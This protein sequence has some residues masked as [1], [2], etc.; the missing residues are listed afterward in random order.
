MYAVCDACP[1]DNW[2]L[3][4]VPVSV[5]SHRLIV[6]IVLLV[7]E[8]DGHCGCRVEHFSVSY[9]LVAKAE[10]DVVTGDELGF[11]CAGCL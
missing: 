6:H 11:S 5:L 4:F 8:R 1:Y 9:S 2:V 3:L 7:Y 10:V